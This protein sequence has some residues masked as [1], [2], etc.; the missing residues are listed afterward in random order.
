MVDGVIPVS[1]DEEAEEELDEITYAQNKDTFKKTSS[2]KPNDMEPRKLTPYVNM[3]CSSN[4]NA[5]HP[6]KLTQKKTIQTE[7]DFHIYDVPKTQRLIDLDMSEISMPASIPANV[8]QET[9]PKHMNQPDVTNT[10]RPHKPD[11]SL[12]MPDQDEIAEDIPPTE[13]VADRYQLGKAER[14][15]MYQN[16]FVLLQ[17]LDMPVREQ[18][19]AKKAYAGMLTRLRAQNKN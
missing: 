2:N 10:D 12:A 16:P 7:A 5:M 1:D 19:A 17:R 4:P 18:V 14:S 9:I 11:V 8:R 3:T 15:N 6:R 13:T